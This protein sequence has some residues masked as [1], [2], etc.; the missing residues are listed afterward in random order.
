[1]HTLD[2]THAGMKR[3]AVEDLQHATVKSSRRIESEEPRGSILEE[4]ITATTIP[5]TQHNVLH[6]TTQDIENVLSAHEELQTALEGPVNSTTRYIAEQSFLDAEVLPSDDLTKNTDSSGATRSI[7]TTSD[8]AE[9]LE[10]QA[11]QRQ[12]AKEF[13]KL[14]ILLI[15]TYRRTEC[16]ATASGA[17]KRL[18]AHLESVLGMVETCDLH[19]NTHLN[20]PFGGLMDLER[21]SKSRQRILE[22]EAEHHECVM[23]FEAALTARTDVVLISLDH[24][25]IPL[26]SDTIPLEEVD[27]TLNAAETHCK[28]ALQQLQLDREEYDYKI[29]LALDVAE[30]A[31]VKLGVLR[32]PADKPGKDVHEEEVGQ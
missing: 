2:F 16:E 13:T 17:S 9:H 30:R 27:E 3:K 4:H 26:P 29:K 25:G 24:G 8:D 32:P 7:G 21:L 28:H 10:A 12:T 23:G 5:P 31:L 11:K 18:D 1:M 6:A 19:M 20:F 22:N 14:L 15:E